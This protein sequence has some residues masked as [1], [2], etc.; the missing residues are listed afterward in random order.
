MA[1]TQRRREPAAVLVGDRCTDQPAW[2]QSRQQPEALR[3]TIGA[4]RV[5][6][7][8][9]EVLAA[10]ERLRLLRL[11]LS[12]NFEADIGVVDGLALRPLEWIP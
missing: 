4:G 3:D 7:V 11:R 5:E 10:D 1:A 2:R 12:P 8:R 6:A 9:R